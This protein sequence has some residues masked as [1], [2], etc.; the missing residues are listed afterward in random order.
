M[1]VEM[2]IFISISI[3]I[4]HGEQACQDV[5]LFFP[6]GP[7][8]LSADVSCARTFCPCRA[9]EVISSDVGFVIIYSPC[10]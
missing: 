3:L 9:V 1:E 8:H 4:A 6:T 2:A 5:N 7:R 10:F